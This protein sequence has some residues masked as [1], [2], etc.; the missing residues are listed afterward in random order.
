MDRFFIP[1]ATAFHFGVI[2]SQMHM[3]W[4]KQF[5]GRIKSDYRYSKDIV[6]N[7]FPWP[8]EVDAAKKAAIEVAA[9]S[10]LDARAAFANQTLAD[11]YDPLAMPKQLRDA[12]VKLDR[13]V[14]KCYRSTQFSSDRQ[15]VEFLFG[16]YERLCRPALPL[17]SP[18]P[19]RRRSPRR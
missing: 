5:C 4:V 6:Y 18:S 12:H 10:V 3:A 13:A 19:A 11:L 8:Q 9:Q 16:L 15:R 17:A 7:N 14:D 1:D 2:S